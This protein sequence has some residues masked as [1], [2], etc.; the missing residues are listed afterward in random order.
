ML[1]AIHPHPT[2]RIGLLDGA[3]TRQHRAAVEDADVVQPEE[4]ALKDIQALFVLAVHPPGEVQ[5]QLV[6]DALQEIA[7][8]PA[9]ALLFDLVDPPAAQAWTGGLTSEKLPS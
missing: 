9:R 2:G 3:A 8:G 1:Q 5:Q 6:K 4:A 7:V